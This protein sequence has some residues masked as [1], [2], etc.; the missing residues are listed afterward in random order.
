M[1]TET[2]P[3]IQLKDYAPAPYLVSETDLTFELDPEATLVTARLR[4]VR[5]SQTPSSQ[6]LKFDGDELKLVSIKLNEKTLATDAY[7]ALA[8]SLVI[9]QTPSDDTFDLEIVTELAPA[10]NTKLWAFVWPYLQ[11]RIWQQNLD[12]V[13]SME[14]LVKMRNSVP[15]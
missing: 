6:A 7:S 2:A 1:R 10:K 12:G 9:H 8:D 3:L 14:L 13:G 11:W 4:V 15:N 5:A